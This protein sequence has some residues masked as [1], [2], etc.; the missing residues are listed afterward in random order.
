MQSTF[1]KLQDAIGR[2]LTRLRDL[3]GVPV[4]IRRNGSLSSGIKEALAKRGLCVVVM[5]PRPHR[6]A[7][8]EAT[9]V[10]S[11]VTQCVRVVENAFTPHGGCDALGVAE[12]VS[13][14]LHGWQP[15]V[16]GITTA[17]SLDSDDAWS[18]PDEP[19]AKGRYTIEV[20]LI[21][22]ASI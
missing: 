15:A 9:P 22:S 21:T 12:R 13:R 18:M 7:S 8:G 11:E 16:P 5:P 4:L 1:V 17:F 3:G 6:A 19:D 10:F 20:N 14:A 2:R